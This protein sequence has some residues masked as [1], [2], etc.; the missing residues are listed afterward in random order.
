MQGRFEEA[1]A[2]MKRAFHLN[3]GSIVIRKTVGDPYYYSGRYEQA[4]EAYR[5]ALKADPGFW[6]A[7]LFLGWSYQQLGETTMALEE[8]KAA[9]DRTGGSSITLGAIGHLHATT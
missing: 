1:E 7:H 2:E 4:I 9:S 8:F 6:M 5:A 3:S